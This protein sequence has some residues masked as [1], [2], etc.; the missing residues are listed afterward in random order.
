MLFVTR[1]EQTYVTSHTYVAELLFGH[2]LLSPFTFLKWP[3][4]N[5]TTYVCKDMFALVYYVAS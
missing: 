3:N 2:F 4:D 1:L 5:L